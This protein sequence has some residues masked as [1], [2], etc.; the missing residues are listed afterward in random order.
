MA[1]KQEGQE[2]PS[3]IYD[4]LVGWLGV[5]LRPEHRCRQMQVGTPKLSYTAPPQMLHPDFSYSAAQHKAFLE[6]G[7]HICEHFL[8]EETMQHAASRIDKLLEHAWSCAQADPLKIYNIHECGEDWVL[9][10]ARQPQL[11]QLVAKHCGSDAEFYLS[12]VIAKPPYSEYSIPW[13][14]D[15]RKSSETLPC[16]VWIALDDANPENGAMAC[17]PGHHTRVLETED[18]GYP[19]FKSAICA[20]ELPADVED[21]SLFYSVKAGQAVVNHPWMPHMSPPNRSGLW[22][23]ALLLRYRKRSGN[24]SPKPADWCCDFRNGE[25]F[26]RRSFCVDA[27]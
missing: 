24:P 13:H 23:K 17:L 9:E 14:Q 11:L 7:Y 25:V 2:L 8:S 19:D 22:R 10:L 15:Y 21:K 1:A 12:H 4:K 26:V 5:P 18:C 20:S 6:R 16:T 3:D 27:C